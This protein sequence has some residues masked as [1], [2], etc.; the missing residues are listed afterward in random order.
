M[1]LLHV[2]HAY[3]PALG[4]AETLVRRLSIEMVQRGHDVMVIAPDYI[5]AEGFFEPGVAAVN[6]VEQ[7]D[8]GVRVVRASMRNRLKRGDHRQWAEKRFSRQLQRLSHDQDFDVVMALPHLLPNV[9]AAA[10][11]ARSR[12][13]PFVMTPL[14]H[15]DDPYWPTDLL[16]ISL[17]QASAVMAMTNTEARQLQA[18]YEVPSSKVFI[19]GLGVD[20]PAI[21]PAPARQDMILVLGRLTASKQ[22]SE[23]VTAINTVWETHPGINL[24]IAGASVPNQDV[25]ALITHAARPKQVEVKRDIDDQTKQSLLGSATC[26]L[27]LSR[28]ESFGL[29]A[30]EAMAAGTPIIALDTE[31]N[32]EVIGSEGGLLV[33]DDVAGGIKQLLDSTSLAGHLRASA[34]ARAVSRFSWDRCVDVFE[35]AY[36]SATVAANAQL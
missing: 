34:R 10:Q 25:E 14:L 23:A 26:L 22:I 9:T 1:R 5:S 33:T 18:S 28:R 32:R 3:H 4:G 7:D 17:Q 20:I 29:V 12:G 31:V 24:V 2:P 15:E 36:H 30:L 8:A 11:L 13:I 35:A 21:D 27:H 6:G 16:R 19:A